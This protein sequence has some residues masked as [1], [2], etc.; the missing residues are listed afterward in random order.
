MVSGC[1]G[2]TSEA[3]ENSTPDRYYSEWQ[4]MKEENWSEPINYFSQL[5]REYIIEEV[6]IDEHVI[7]KGTVIVHVRTVSNADNHLDQSVFTLPVV[8]HITKPSSQYLGALF[9]RGYIKIVFHDLED[10]SDPGLIPSNLL[11]YRYV[12][13]PAGIPLSNLTDN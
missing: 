13:I 12:I 7:S 4:P 3:A 8:L 11:E 2:I 5:K 10:E 9:N 6:K 1:D